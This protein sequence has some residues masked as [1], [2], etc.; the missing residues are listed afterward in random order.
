MEVESKTDYI[1]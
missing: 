1:F